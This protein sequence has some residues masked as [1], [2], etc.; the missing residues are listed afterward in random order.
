M[1]FNLFGKSGN[2]AE[3]SKHGSL[4][5]TGW[6]AFAENALTRG[7]AYIWTSQ[8]ANIDVGD[9]MLIVRNDSHTQ[10]LVIIRVEVTN[11][12]AISRYEIHKVTAAYAASNA[13]G[14]EI[15]AGGTDKKA[16]ATASND[17]TANAQGTVFAEIGGGVAVETYHR[18]TALVLN[19]GEAIGVDQVTE[20]AAGA[21]TIYGYFLDNNELGG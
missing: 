19:R 14:T 12:D 13:T 7:D 17:E 21:C 9:T 18:D 5:I 15:N 6:D 20:S 10:K 8:D 2:Q 16:P 3:V 4:Q 11:G 1:L